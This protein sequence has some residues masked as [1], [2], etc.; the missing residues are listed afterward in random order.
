MDLKSVTLTKQLLYE[1][2]TGTAVGHGPKTVLI[3][4]KW[5]LFRTH[6]HQDLRQKCVSRQWCLSYGLIS[7]LLA[8][9]L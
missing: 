2:R 7:K 3:L 8:S 4:G 1:Q 6:V 9:H 5:L